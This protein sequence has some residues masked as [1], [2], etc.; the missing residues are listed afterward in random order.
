[1]TDFTWKAEYAVGVPAIDDHHRD[2][3][4]LVARIEAADP[5][6]PTLP[7]L[8][9]R[10][11]R[12]MARHFAEEEAHMAAIGYPDLPRHHQDHA[13]FL[14]WLDS[15]KRT[16]RASAQAP[17]ELGETVNAYLEQWMVNHILRTDMRY[18]DFTVAHGA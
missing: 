7:E 4:A 10:L 6:G 14:V 17:F 13:D 9:A 5:G 12:D 18:R 11:D 8:I 3:F 2:L 15:V 1:M 16:Y